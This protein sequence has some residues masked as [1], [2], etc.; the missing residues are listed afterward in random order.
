MSIVHVHDEWAPLEE[1]IVGRI[2]GA[3][4]PTPDAGLMA[5]EYPELTSPDE[6]PSGPFPPQ[7]M[8]E[9]AE[10]LALLA[11]ALE[12]LGVRVRR[13]ER[14]DHARRFRSLD[15]ETEGFA[16]LCPRDVLLPVGETIIETPLC[17]RARQYET[18]SYRPLLMEYF[19]S[20]AGWFAAP[21]P[22]LLDSAYRHLG[23]EHY[24]LDESEPIFDAANVL[25]VGRDILYQVSCSG[26][27]LG[28]RWL[29]RVLGPAYRVHV[30][31]DLYDGTH[32]DSTLALVRP[33]LVF[34]NPARVSRDNLPSI[35]RKWDVVYFSDVVD[36]GSVGHP[37]SSVWLGL[38]FMMVN[39][40]LAV[41]DR[42]QE[43]LIR[44]LERRGV[45]VLPLVIR[46][47]RTLGG[48]FHCMTLDVRRRGGLES[49]C[50]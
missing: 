29:Q 44:E 13:P 9:T 40:R 17:L 12:K 8:E 30:V 24:L 19:Q 50:D 43:P 5:T 48:G 33:G 23:G 47:S 18:L 49:Y 32:L 39:P 11:E 4:I 22:R 28:G 7:V 21:R 10:D 35:F 26:N 38:N 16:N 27:H 3:R 20:G 6:V 25:R 36:T 46:H 2:D 31:D 14:H 45:D 42:R 34:A 15:W 37:I 41:V 1:V